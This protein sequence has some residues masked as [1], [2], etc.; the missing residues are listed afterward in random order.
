MHIAIN[1]GG[2]TGI[3]FSPH[4][5]LGILSSKLLVIFCDPTYSNSQNMITLH[6]LIIQIHL[7]KQIDVTD[8]RKCAIRV[9][10][11]FN[12]YIIMIVNLESVN[13]TKIKN[14]SIRSLSIIRLYYYL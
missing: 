9:V 1:N 13:S 8:T 12:P 2:I 7:I 11:M 5:N 4:N 10:F 6:P 14:K 3:V